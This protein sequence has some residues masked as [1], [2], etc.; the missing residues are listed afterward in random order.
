MYVTA[1]VEGKVI[2]FKLSPGLVRAHRENRGKTM[3]DEEAAAFVESKRRARPLRRTKP[4]PEGR[5]WRRRQHLKPRR[6]RA[7]FAAIRQLIRRT[8]CGDCLL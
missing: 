6:G 5:S 7:P 3:T 4:H 1:V 2:R 8:I